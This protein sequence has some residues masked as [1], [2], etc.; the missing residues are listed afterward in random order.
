MRK[1]LGS[2]GAVTLAVLA[3]CNLAPAYHPPAVSTPTAFKEA[4]P[5]TQAAPADALQRGAWWTDRKS[6]V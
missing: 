4:A 2:L 3:G 6:V 5:W 1:L